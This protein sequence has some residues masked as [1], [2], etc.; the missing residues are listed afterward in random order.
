M[1]ENTR[2]PQIPRTVWWGLRSIL[3]RSPKATIDDRLLGVE[4]GVQAAA[5]KA[6][7]AE[8]RN[9]G[10]LTEDGK[11][12]PL[13]HRWRLDESYTEAVGEIIRANYPEGLIHVAPPGRA[14]RD[15]VIAWFKRDGLGE[16]SAGNKAA[17]YL[18]L[19]TPSPNEAPKHL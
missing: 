4:L 16:G 7:I 5:A 10:H 1:P 12:T 11:G 2:Y 18:L 3:N 15:K 17:T 8:L 6:Y 14:D 9:A 19:S 13:A